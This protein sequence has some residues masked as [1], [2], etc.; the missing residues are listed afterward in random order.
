MVRRALAACFTCAIIA[1]STRSFVG[2]RWQATR[3]DGGRGQEARTSSSLPWPSLRPFTGT[4]TQKCQQLWCAVAGLAI[5]LRAFGGGRAVGHEAQYQMREAK[6]KREAA[7]FF[8]YQAR[9]L[10]TGIPPR[11][12]LYWRREERMLF[13]TTKME[14]GINFDAY[15]DVEVDR[16]GGLGDEVI[17]DSFQEI[18]QQFTM[19]QELVENVL[20]RCGYDKP[21][22][23]QKHSVPAALSGNDV[24]VCAQT[25]SGKTAAFLVP[26][27][28]E[29]LVAGQNKLEEG[30]IKPSAVIMAPTREL[31]QQ[32][33][34]EARKLCFRTVARVVAVYGGADALPQLKALAEGAEIIICTPGRLEDFLERGVVSMRKVKY[35]ILD[36]ADR[37]L[38]MGFEPQIRS[39][40]EGHSMPESGGEEGRQ[41]M[42]F[43]ATFPRE[44]QDLALDFLDPT[45]LWIGVGRVGEACDN[46]VQRFQ[47]ASTTDL[48]GKFEML[49]DAV[50]QVETESDAKVAKTLVFANSKTT[51]DAITW[52]LSD[53]RIRS[54]QIHGGLSQA[55]RDRALSDFRNGRVSVLVA[56]DVAARGLDLPGIDHVVNYEMP[57][58]AEDYTHR[59]GRTGR[60]GNTGLSTSLVGSWEPAL[61]D[62]LKSVRDMKSASIPEWLEYHANSGGRGGRGGGY[63]RQ[64]NQSRKAEMDDGRFNPGYSRPRGPDVRRQD[65][66]SRRP[67]GQG[68]YPRRVNST[69][70]TAGGG[71][72]QRKEDLPPWARG[73][74]PK[75]RMR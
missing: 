6:R 3:L 70:P 37:M 31:C 29:T 63:V 53:A 45:Y 7:Q 73:L 66:Q 55:A 18:C 42:M 27:I 62:I 72:R 19:P 71:R 26:L 32:I 34:L 58:N 24:M 56:T 33:A 39:I 51:V 23:V 36:E 21:T 4:R 38:D 49:V 22:P 43:S 52:R 16:R 2:S 9:L 47:D 50:S 14:K 61:R 64:Y 15:D 30:A 12:D 74:P 35:C 44:M 60:I 68:G 67:R 69:S 5:V 28:A 75:Q 57:L 11:D 65:T 1:S 13:N 48:D 17:C 46:V 54:M 10:R 40:I 8:T 25:G 59:I 41:T 20:Y